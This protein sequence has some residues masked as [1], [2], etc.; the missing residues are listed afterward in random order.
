MG[1]RARPER[2]GAHHA[3]QANTYYG[4]LLKNCDD[5]KHS[6]LP[7]LRDAKTLVAKN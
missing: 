3:A 5:G 1:W 7:A 6:E 2:R 4:Q